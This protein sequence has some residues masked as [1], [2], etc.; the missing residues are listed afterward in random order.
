MRKYFEKAYQAFCY[1]GESLLE[2]VGVLAEIAMV[3]F[4]Y[5]T[6]PVWIIPY[7]ICKKLKERS[8]DNA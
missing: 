3:A 8:A 7:A 4:I 5:L 6:V 1:I 2:L